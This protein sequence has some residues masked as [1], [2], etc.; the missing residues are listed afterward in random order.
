MSDNELIKQLYLQDME[1]TFYLTSGITIKRHIKIS[2]KNDRVM[3]MTLARDNSDPFSGDVIHI[4]DVGETMHY[5]NS[6][7][8]CIELAEQVHHNDVVINPWIGW[9][10]GEAY[11]S[12]GESLISSLTRDG[13]RPINLMTLSFNIQQIAF[14]KTKVSVNPI[15][16]RQIIIHYNNISP[17][18]INGESIFNVSPN[19]PLIKYFEEIN[20]RCPKGTTL[21]LMEEMD[22]SLEVCKQINEQVKQ[23]YVNYMIEI[24]VKNIKN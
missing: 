10:L 11:T 23:H 14:T 6:Q 19:V 24:P 12:E 13:K 17:M 9:D 21:S 16:K 3:P 15:N 1:V 4:F 7:L 5:S 20:H 2:K 8:N 18:G 22:L